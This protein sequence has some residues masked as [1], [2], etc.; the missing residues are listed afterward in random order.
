MLNFK[1]ITPDDRDVFEEFYQYKTIQNCETSFANLCGWGFLFNG[2]Y[3]IINR[4]LVTRVHYQLNKEICYHCPIGPTDK[5]ELVKLIIQDS[6]ENN[7]EM[8]FI[9]DCKEVIQVYFKEEFEVEDKREYYD[10]VYLR[11]SLASLSGKKLQSKRNHCNKFENLYN[12]EYR[13]LNSENVKICIGFAQR[14]LNYKIEINNNPD[15]EGYINEMKVIN[16]FSDNFDNLALIGGSL[17]VDGDLVAFTIGSKINNDTFCTHIEKAN[18]DYE[19]AYA[20]INRELAK[21]LP[22]NYVYINREE[23]LGIEGLRKAK[24]SYQP[25]KLIEK[26]IATYI[27]DI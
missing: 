2:E 23:D 5:V 1:R 21:H 12:Y 16:Y 15:I 3:A 25:I 24:L 27:N 6:I 7:Y 18:T 26:Q 11:E 13:E 22:E 20:M 10:Y 19:G 4:A 8:K 14:W 17:F 9:L